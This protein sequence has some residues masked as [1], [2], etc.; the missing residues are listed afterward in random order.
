[1]AGENDDLSI[2]LSPMQLAAVLAG[3]TIE[4]PHTVRNRFFGALTVVGGAIELV[5][6]A[7]LLLA[8]EP[9][10]T[11]KMAGGALGVHGSDTSWTGLR[12]VWTGRVQTTLTAQAAEAAARSLG[13]DPSTAGEVG[14]AIDIA[15]PLAAGFIGLLRAIAVR[16]GVI[17]LA[18]EEAAGG[19]TIARHVGRT[20]AQLR[21]RLAQQLA[22]PAAS[23]FRN[24]GEAERFVSAALRANA[25]AIQSWA[26][27]AGPG[28]TR[29]FNYTGRNIGYGVE[30]A[31]NALRN[32]DNIVVVI[33]KAQ[34]G[35][36]IYFVLTAYPKP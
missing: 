30:R 11:T 3:D 12:Q 36:R 29:A 20:E 18:A 4:P 26:R 23:S 8:P 14:V 6:A 9:T 15:V 35:N 34:S 27:S 25:Q 33:R 24:L 1:L 17:S 22:I 28:A 31:T 13:A 32:M 7:A 21:A 10:M 5:G 16:R 19:H 2:V